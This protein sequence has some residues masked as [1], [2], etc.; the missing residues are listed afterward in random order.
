MGHCNDLLFTLGFSVVSSPSRRC[1]V[2]DINATGCQM[3]KSHLLKDSIARFPACRIAHASE[4]AR[5]AEGF[6][7][8][9]C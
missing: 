8:G 1:N 5:K 2:H 4:D 6:H 7:S 3:P 9:R